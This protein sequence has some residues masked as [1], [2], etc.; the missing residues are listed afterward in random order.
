MTRPKEGRLHPVRIS[1]TARI[2]LLLRIWMLAARVTWLLRRRPVTEVA[3]RLGSLGDRRR[4]P[5][6]LLNRAVSRSLRVGSAQP[7]CIIRSFVLYGLLREQGDDAVLVIGLPAEARSADAHA[8]VEFDEQ[9]IGP[10]PG[11][12]GYTPMARYPRAAS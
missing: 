8:W 10:L 4:Q 3:E 6:P 9:D 5:I 12:R 11:S 1:F 7:R 2:L